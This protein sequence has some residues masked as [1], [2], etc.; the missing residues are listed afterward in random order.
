MIL[1]S[2][3]LLGNVLSM[4]LSSYGY[5]VFKP[6]R[7]NNQE[8]L[9]CNTINNLIISEKIPTVINLMAN[10]NVDYCEEYP[11]F[12]YLSNV[13]SLE[14]LIEIFDETGIHLIHIS[15]DQIYYGEGPH[16]EENIYPC[17]VYAI[18][19][20]LSEVIADKVDAT[21]LRTNFVGKSFLSKRPSFSDWILNSIK[22]EKPISLF[23]DIY[24]SPLSIIDLCKYI[25]IVIKSSNRGIFNIGSR[26]SISKANFGI[27]L[28]KNLNLDNKMISI[29]S[30]RKFER[31]AK[32]PN[33]MTMS[34]TK[35]EQAF[36]L[37]LPTIDET[38]KALYR[39][40]KK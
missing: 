40:Y 13:K 30:S 8:F 29:C 39:E 36:D 16:S 7:K 20:Y 31:K 21:I 2:S 18:T 14:N 11:E 23:N 12:A 33:D 4:K 27:E 32:R 38:N 37:I 15:T 3:G 26:N 6:L 35:F 9:D 22:N 1:G 28:I 19:K 17:N 34:V 25:D 5:K 24:F 10:T